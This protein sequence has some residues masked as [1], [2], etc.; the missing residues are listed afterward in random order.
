MLVFIFHFSSQHKKREK[1]EHAPQG[2]RTR[3]NPAR[4]SAQ[5]AE[6]GPGPLHENQHP[7][8]QKPLPG[9]TGAWTALRQI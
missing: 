4:P 5:I 7:S 1:S 8:Q 9:A 3:E 2:H 6:L